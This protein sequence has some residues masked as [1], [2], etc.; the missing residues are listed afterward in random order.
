MLRG[1][2]AHVSSRRAITARPYDDDT[3]WELRKK[4]RDSE[5]WCPWPDSNQHDLTAT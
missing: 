3:A 1:S 5:R 2:D 4:G